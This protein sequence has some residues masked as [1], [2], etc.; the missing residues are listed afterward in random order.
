MGSRPRTTRNGR[1]RPGASQG[2]VA[3]AWRRPGHPN[4]VEHA[5]LGFP[6][7]VRGCSAGTAAGSATGLW[8]GCRPIVNEIK[9]CHDFWRARHLLGWRRPDHTDPAQHVGLGLALWLLFMAI[10]GIRRAAIRHR[11]RKLRIATRSTTILKRFV[12]TGVSIVIVGCPAN[13]HEAAISIV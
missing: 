5:G 1:C 8:R 4:P 9:A 12:W 6:L 11:S 2:D 7:R 10:L 3:G 13:P